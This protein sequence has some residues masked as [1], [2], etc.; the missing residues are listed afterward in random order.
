MSLNPST[1]LSALDYVLSD[2]DMVL[3]MTVNPGFGGQ[4]FIPQSLSKIADLKWLVD[5]QGLDVDIEVDGGV[6]VQN[7]SAIA[8]AGANVFVAGNTVFSSRDYK[9]TI[10]ALKENAR[11]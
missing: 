10:R 11:G 4:K 2:L 3:I 5:D 8:K 6:T 7:I 9:K 1:S